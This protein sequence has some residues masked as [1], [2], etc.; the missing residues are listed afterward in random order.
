[1][2]RRKRKRLEDRFSA[3]GGSLRPRRRSQL[4]R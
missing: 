1:M 2:R 4:R 3:I